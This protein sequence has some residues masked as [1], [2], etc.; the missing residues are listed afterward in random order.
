MNRIAL[1]EDHHRLGEMIARALLNAGLETDVF[2]DIETAL[3]AVMEADYA[4]VVV[5]RG[6]PDGDGLDLLRALR[7]AGNQIPCLILTARDALRDRVTGLEAGADDYLPKPFA[8]EE[9]VARVRALMRRPQV[10]QSLTPEYMGLR[11]SP[12]AREMRYG[13][14]TIS[15]ATAE[16]QIMLS[17]VRAGG[18]V[19]RR[20]R[21]ENAAWGLGEAVTPNALDV[22]LH[23]LRKKLQA[24]G[25]DLMIANIRGH[26]YALQ[27]IT[28]VG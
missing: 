22:A 20:A 2:T 25:C 24:I 13:E 28:P 27:H 9:M 14:D 11:V 1:I 15:L 6:L 4:A 7:R 10:M 12:E 5:D 16:L 19:V 23:R 26:G 17:L 21:L 8:M 3:P 18:D